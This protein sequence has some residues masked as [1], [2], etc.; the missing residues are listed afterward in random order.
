[1]PRLSDTSATKPHS[2]SFTSVL[3]PPVTKVRI[4]PKTLKPAAP[5]RR[6]GGVKLTEAEIRRAGK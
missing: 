4:D 6:G 1:M 3:M 2:F 5:A